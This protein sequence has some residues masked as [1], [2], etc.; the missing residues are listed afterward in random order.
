VERSDIELFYTYS[1]RNMTA[2]HRRLF[3]REFDTVNT[4]PDNRNHE[5][6]AARRLLIRL[7]TTNDYHGDLRL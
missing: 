6:Q 5:V 3:R 4:S 2:E 1:M 7:L